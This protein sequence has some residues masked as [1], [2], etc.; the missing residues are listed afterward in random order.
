MPFSQIKSIILFGA[1][2][3][4]ASTEYQQ[5][6]KPHFGSLGHPETTAFLTFLK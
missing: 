2:T 6:D 4:Y 1:Y 5:I 3:L